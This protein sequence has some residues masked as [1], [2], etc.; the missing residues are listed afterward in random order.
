MT[1][2]ETLITL[3][4]PPAA[5]AGAP[6]DWHSIEAR[7]GT[8][9]PRDYKAYCDTYGHGLFFANWNL[10]PLTPD[11]PERYHDLAGTFWLDVLAD[12]ELERTHRP[13]P[14]PGGLLAIATSELKHRL[15][16]QTGGEPDEWPVLIQSDYGDYFELE[17]TATGYI[18]QFVD[19][20]PYK[21]W[22]SDAE[23]TEPDD[24]DEDEDEDEEC[25]P[26]EFIASGGACEITGR[27][28]PFVITSYGSFNDD[29]VVELDLGG[30]FGEPRRAL[31]DELLA[32]LPD[33]VLKRICGAEAKRSQEVVHVDFERDL[34]PVRK[35]IQAWANRRA[36]Y[37]G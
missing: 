23:D 27:Y 33:K 3:V 22:A 10:Y 9:L 2:L 14:E 34:E 37:T 18:A 29:R 7:M 20:D 1:A 30:A 8:R 5:P 25:R 24:D 16:W 19:G 13:Y 17:V 26:P 36:G 11:A 6:F 28:E 15:W 31:L 32:D 35:A 12:D 4:A 21:G